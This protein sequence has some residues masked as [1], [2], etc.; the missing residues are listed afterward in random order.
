M[1]SSGGYAFTSLSAGGR[2]AYRALYVG[3]EVGLYMREMG[4][5]LEASAGPSLYGGL[6]FG[7]KWKLDI[8]WR[9]FPGREQSLSF[10]LLGIRYSW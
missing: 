6:T 3:L 8:G 2:Y 9:L 5:A 7:S 10:L 1:G 4:D